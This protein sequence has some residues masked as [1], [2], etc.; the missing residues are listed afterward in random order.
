MDPLDAL[1]EIS[2]YYGQDPAYVLAG[3]GNTSYKDS[4]KIWIK[5]SGIS[6]ANIRKEDFV[7]LSRER[8]AV[9]GTRTYSPDPVTREAQVKSD[10]NQAV[11]GN[12]TLRPSVET[13][14]HNLI[15]SAYIVHTHPTVINALMCANDAAREVEERFGKLALFI[16]Y[17]DPGYTLF[18]VLQSRIRA[19]EEKFAAPPELIFLQNHGIFV[20]GDTPQE[21]ME[22]YA[23]AEAAIREGK[24]WQV[25]DGEM[26]PYASDVSE[27]AADIYRSHGWICKGYRSPLTDHFSAGPE[28]FDRVSRPFTPDGI[29][30]CKSRYLMLEPHL[31][32]EAL[33]KQILAFRDR[34]GYL[35]KVMME[36]GAG[37][38]A[39]GANERDM[40]TV[41]DVFAQTMKVCYLTEQF[42]GPHA[43]SEEQ[44]RFIDSWEVENYRRKVAGS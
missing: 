37:M 2:R 32:R 41:R 15:S 1:V 4:E 25:P 6:L 40:L 39:A 18:K 23:A 30:Y 36:K 14:L 9:I 19:F 28:A 33:G 27:F 11:T 10:L 21:I 7:V 24:Q 20:G 26:E 29:V 43:M 34:Y 16:E 5:A 35:P 38:M 3:G 12:T 17:T 44:I 22:I 42:G 13:S 8:L 31:S